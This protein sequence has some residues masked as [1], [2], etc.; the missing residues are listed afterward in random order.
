MQRFDKPTAIGFGSAAMGMLGGWLVAGVIWY[1]T[2]RHPPLNIPAPP[3]QPIDE[4]MGPSEQL[5]AEDGAYE[6][7]EPGAPPTDDNHNGSVDSGEAAP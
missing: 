3:Q 6:M 4:E 7:A 5:E 2:A 1:F